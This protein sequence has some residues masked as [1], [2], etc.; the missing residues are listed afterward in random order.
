MYRKEKDI[1][2]TPVCFVWGLAYAWLAVWVINI[3]YWV[4]SITIGSLL[5]SIFWTDA[6]G[7][8]YVIHTFIAMAFYAAVLPFAVVPISHVYNPWIRRLLIVLYAFS[9]ICIVD[10]SVSSYF[11]SGNLNSMASFLRNDC[12]FHLIGGVS[13][14]NLTWSD[15][16]SQFEYNVFD[17]YIVI[18]AIVCLCNKDNFK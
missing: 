10:K 12:Y 17:I 15:K 6:R 14:L 3:F 4:E 13:F 5:G 18:T 16:L 2:M 8:L 9:I 11:F 7:P 1:L